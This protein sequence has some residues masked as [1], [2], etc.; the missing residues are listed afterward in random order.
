[1]SSCQAFLPQLLGAIA[2]KPLTV[3]QRVVGRLDQREAKG[4]V[5]ILVRS[6]A[7]FSQQTVLILSG[8]SAIKADAVTIGPAL[9][10][11]RLWKELGIDR[12]I[13]KRLA[14]RRFEFDV[15]RA[16]LLTVFHRLFVSGSDRSCERWRCDYAVTGVAGLSL[17]HMHRAMAFLGEP[18]AHQ[19][20][21]TPFSPRCLKDLV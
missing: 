14:E 7:R 18:L 21:A 1:M 4:G 6:P 11:E 2:R 12:V 17:H 15:E 19:T 5:E 3:S 16:I 8:K 10:F 13:H 9:A 20:N